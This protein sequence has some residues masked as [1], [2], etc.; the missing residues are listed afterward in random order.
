MCRYLLHKVDEKLSFERQIYVFHP[1]QH[2][3]GIFTGHT[4]TQ[5]RIKVILILTDKETGP[6]MF[7]KSV[8]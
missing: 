4:I 8:Y 2:K 6:K 5:V 1:V 7:S 3:A